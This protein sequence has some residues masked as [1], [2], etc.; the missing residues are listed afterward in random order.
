MLNT[1]RCSCGLG[2]AD[3]S[4]WRTL[5]TTGWICQGELG[6]IQQRAVSS[7]L[8]VCPSEG[9]VVVPEVLALIVLAAGGAH[10]RCVVAQLSAQHGCTAS[11]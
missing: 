8:P 1:K 7:F 6:W 9:G 5:L 3:H 4:V 10:G 2:S 11:H